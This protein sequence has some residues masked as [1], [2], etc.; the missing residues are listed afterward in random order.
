MGGP[1]WGRSGF[2]ALQAIDLQNFDRIVLDHRSD[3]G[4]AGLP[5]QQLWAV[6]CDATAACPGAQQRVV[7]GV[8]AL[9]ALSA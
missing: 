8:V 6:S 2:G 7:S 3:L 1:I 4:L 5:D 9:I